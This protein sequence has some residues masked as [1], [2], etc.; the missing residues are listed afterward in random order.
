MWNIGKQRRRK[1]AAGTRKLNLETL[2]PRLTLSANASPF[3]TDRMEHAS[4]WNA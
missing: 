4:Q 2:E 1:Q 3:L